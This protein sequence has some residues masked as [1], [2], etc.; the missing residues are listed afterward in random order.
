MK[1]VVEGSYDDDE[2][3]KASSKILRDGNSIQKFQKLC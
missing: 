2:D 3:E 1:V